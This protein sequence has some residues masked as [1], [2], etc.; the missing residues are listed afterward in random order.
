MGA[1]VIVGFVLAWVWPLVAPPGATATTSPQRPRKEWPLP[2]AEPKQEP[3]E[4]TQV[5]ELPKEP[6]AS[7]V[8]ESQRLSFFVTPLM[9]QG[10]LS[11][12]VRQA[13]RVLLAQVRGAQVVK[14]RAFV[15]GTGDLRRVQAVVSETFTE[16]RLPLPALSVVQVGALPLAGAQVVLEAVA[17]ERK[18]VN[19][20]GLAFISGQAATAPDPLAPPAPLLE[21]SL[22]GLRTALRAAGSDD[23][24]VLRVT[25]FIASFD[26]WSHLRQQMARAFPR[27]ALNLLQ[28]QRAPTRA[29]V[30]CEAVARLKSPPPSPFQLLNPPELPRSPHYSQIALVGPVRLVF[31][32]AQLGFRTTEQDVRLAFQRL[33]R[34]L[35]EAGSSFQRVAMSH[36]YPLSGATGE[37]LRRVRAEFYDQQAP[38]AS[39]MLPFEGLPSLD[40]SFGVDVVAV[41]APPGPRSAAPSGPRSSP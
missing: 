23:E 21:Q 10:L 37:L 3:E 12:Q 29:L 15:A 1:A 16:R 4:P 41:L 18:A 32:G 6:P 20:H 25:C 31:T 8:A 39:T 5:L 22:S 28:P 35:Q 27:A 40:A 30:E 19:P 7:V 26:D 2:V 14:L 36:L 13:L 24:N 9:Q 34:T 33:G 38:P 11:Q 17:Q